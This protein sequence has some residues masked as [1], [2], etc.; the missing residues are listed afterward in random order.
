MNGYE[1]RKAKKINNI[2]AA[3][4][5]LFMHYGLQKVNINEIAKKAGV[6]P[7]TIFNYYGS[8]EQL[9]IDVLTFQMNA[10]LE[11]YERIL[12]EDIP[13]TEKTKQIIFGEI[14]VLSRL[15]RVYGGTDLEL[16]PVLKFL[17]TYEEDKLL[18]FFTRYIEAG[19]QE[20]FFSEDYNV[21][22]L[23]AYFD[24]YKRQ[25]IR[26]METLPESEQKPLFER[27]TEFFFYGLT[28]RRA[29]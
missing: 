26:I 29:E 27:F 23:L 22:H 28:G 17:Q 19:Q 13:F 9:I 25:M 11:R 2:R 8:K 3:A 16:S 7:A 6:S 4:M 21:S 5:D 24:M 14:E 15:S 10:Q 12:H 20:G 1:R 18:P